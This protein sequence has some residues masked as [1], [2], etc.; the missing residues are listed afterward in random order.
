MNKRI[1]DTKLC[2]PNMSSF[3]KGD[4]AAHFLEQFKDAPKAFLAHA[5][6]LEDDARILR[7]IAGILAENPDMDVQAMTHFI[8][9][10]GPIAIMEKYEVEG[11]LHS[12]PDDAFDDED[13]LDDEDFEDGDLG[14]TDPA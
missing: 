4:D 8:G 3:K 10:E 9:I 13:D 7:R 5:E 6:M 2:E 12:W 14:D 1:R 11:L